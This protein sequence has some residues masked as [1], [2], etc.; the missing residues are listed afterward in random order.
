MFESRL[1][2]CQPGS[3]A[4]DSFTGASHSCSKAN[5]YVTYF[6]DLH[7]MTCD[8]KNHTNSNTYRW[9]S[10]TSRNSPNLAQ[11][12]SDLTATWQWVAKSTNELAGRKVCFIS[13]SK[14]LV[15]DGGER[16]WESV[17]KTI[18]GAGWWRE[19][20][21]PEEVK[22]DSLEIW[23][24]VLCDWQTWSWVGRFSS[25]CGVSWY[26][27]LFSYRPKSSYE[28]CDEGI[29]ESGWLQIPRCRLGWRCDWLQR[30]TRRE[31]GCCIGQSQAFPV[32][33]RNTSFTMDRSW[34][35]WY[36]NLC[37]LYM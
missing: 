20:E 28:G 8:H 18:Q 23:G 19:E 16:V 9:Y 10:I 31:E 12:P 37:A 30:N 35:C 34:E 33:F 21:I 27:Q 4:I 13:C 15:C 25:T 1:L 29:Q 17:V 24:S 11:R 5:H 32:S 26:F 6:H 2:L 7:C 22:Y 3:S 14:S 36:G